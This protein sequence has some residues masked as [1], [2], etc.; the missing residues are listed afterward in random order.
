MTTEAIK[1]DRP[2]V[3]LLI[4]LIGMMAGGFVSRHIMLSKVAEAVIVG[5]MVIEGEP[6][7]LQKR[8]MSK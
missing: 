6:Y 2:F 1:I 3:W 7:T 4:F 8:V 5:G